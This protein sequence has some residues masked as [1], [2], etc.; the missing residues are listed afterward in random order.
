VIMGG[1][2]GSFIIGFI[3]LLVI[4]WVR[5]RLLGFCLV[6]SSL[7]LCLVAFRYVGDRFDFENGV[8]F[9]R[10][11]SLSSRR[12]AQET[13]A[14]ATVTWRERRWERGMEDIRNRPWIGY[15]YGGLENAFV[16]G[17][18]AQFE[19]AMVDIDVAN[20]TLHNGF[21]ASA[22]AF[23]IPGVLLFMIA[24]L[25]RIVFNAKRI[26][27]FR[28]SDPVVSDLH[29]FVFANLV[30]MIAGLYV[31]SDFNNPILWTYITIGDLVAGVKKAEGETASVLAEQ[32]GPLELTPRP[33]LS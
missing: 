29:C 30:A 7:V 12:V 18:S 9:F 21:L 11:L 4:A 13:G 6:A 19:S 23:G 8:G 28:T 2:R 16:F 27:R 20:G 3:L 25:G 14:D 17:T 15:G 1:N 26:V 5:R 24:Y 33:V 22:R 32:E 31:G 10:I